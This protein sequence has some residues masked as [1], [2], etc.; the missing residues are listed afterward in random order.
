MKEKS[1]ADELKTLE[2]K[3]KRGGKRSPKDQ[4]EEGSTS[5]PKSKRQK[6]IVETLRVDEPKEEPEADV[7]GDNVRLSPE[8]ERL[9]KSLNEYNAKAEKAAGD[10]EDNSSS[11]SKE[12]VDEN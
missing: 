1:A 12:E 11:S 2:E 5:Q 9:L 10:N 3:K 4:V 8:S 7:E 6:K